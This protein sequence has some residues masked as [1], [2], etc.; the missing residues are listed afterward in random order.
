MTCNGVVVANSTTNPYLDYTSY[1]SSEDEELRI[2]MVTGSYPYPWVGW[3]DGIR[4][5]VGFAR[6]TA[7]IPTDG[8]TPS[9]E[10]DDGRSSNTV[11]QVLDAGSTTGT[12]KFYGINTHTY[13]QTTHYATGHANTKL[14]V[15][16]DDAETANDGV[17]MY[18]KTGFHLEFKDAGEGTERDYN[19][20]NVGPN[21]LGSDTSMTSEFSDTDTSFL[22]RSRPNQANGSH[23]LINEVTQSTDITITG[24][25]FH[26]SGATPNTVFSIDSNTANVSISSGGTKNI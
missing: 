20:F 15:R 23:I 9:R 2:G 7:G 4:A 17:Y 14:M 13:L 10:H 3:M 25:C 1:V 24:D 18:G 5:T 12:R 19:N 22:L 16:G 11:A 26:S 21:G 6:Y 8:Q